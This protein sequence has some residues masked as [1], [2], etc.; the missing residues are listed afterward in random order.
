M[1]TRK[2]LVRDLQTY[3]TLFVEEEIFKAKFLTLLDHPR[4]FHRDHLPGHI[5]GSA[6]IVNEGFSKILLVL[7]AKLGRWLQP[8]GH[9]D[10]NENVLNVALREA[11]EETGLKSIKILSPSVFD[12]D[13]HLIPARNDF[14]EHLH[15]DV[16]FLLQA[17]EREALTISYESSDLKWFAVHEVRA[18]TE[19]APSIMRMVSKTSTLPGHFR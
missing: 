11:E 7:H 5:T 18:L 6:W 10:G 12:I 4:G 8:G 15:Y 17:S 2:T 14:P 13:I 16:R 9:A 1:I 19:N 3:S